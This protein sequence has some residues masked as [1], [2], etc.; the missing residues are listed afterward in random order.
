VTVDE[1]RP[2]VVKVTHDHPESDDQ[3]FIGERD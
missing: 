3:A 2:S 1:G